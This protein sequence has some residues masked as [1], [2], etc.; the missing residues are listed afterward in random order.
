[1]GADEIHP[2]VLRELADVVAKPLP[3]IS[4]KSWQSREHPGNWKKGNIVPLFKKGRK[5]EPGNSRPLSLTSVPG[6]IMEQILLEAMLKHMEVREVIQ[7]SQHGFTKGKSCLTK[8]V[9][10]YDGVTTSVDKGRAMDVIYLDFCKAFDM[11]PHSILLSKL[12]G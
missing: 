6:K 1:M 5:E 10:F 7:N 3:I 8:L 12:E 11:V 2:R 4:E 9:A